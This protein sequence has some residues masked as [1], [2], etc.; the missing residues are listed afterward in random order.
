VWDVVYLI[1]L[2]GIGVT[3]AGRRMSKLLCK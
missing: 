2:F 1:I 3:V